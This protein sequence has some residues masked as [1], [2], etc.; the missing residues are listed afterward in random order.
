MNMKFIALALAA[1]ALPTAAFAAELVV[2]AAPSKGQLALSFDMVSDGDVAGFNFKV[3]VPGLSDQ[4]RKLP[5]CVAELPKG[6]SGDCSV[7]KEGIYVYAVSNSPDIALPAGVNSIGKVVVSYPVA[8]A[9]AK[10]ELGLTVTELAAANN[11]AQEI[12]ISSR[13]E[14]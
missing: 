12:S 1:C 14:Y 11:S 4:S 8:L 10:G 2:T 13:V 9:K 7:T 6:F 5:Q 3:N